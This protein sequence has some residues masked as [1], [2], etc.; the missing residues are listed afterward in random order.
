MADRVLLHIGAP[1]S[2]STFV[3]SLLWK[4]RSA[5]RG[6]GLLVPGRTPFDHNLA[7]MAV[8][9]A[10]AHSRMQHRAAATWQRLLGRI[11]QWPGSVVLS[12]EWFCWAA[13]DGVDR[14]LA[15]LAPTP[16]H[17]LFTA[18]AIAQQVPAAW[19]ETLKV[20][21]G[22]S[23]D[24]FVERLD[25]PGARWSW[26]T[27]DPAE[28]LVRWARSVPTERVHLA[29][30]PPRGSDPGLLW[31]RVCQVLGIDAAAYDADSPHA[32]ESLGVESAALL[33][34]AGPQLRDAILDEDADW[35]DPYR[36][37]RNYLGHQLLVPRRGS[38]IALPAPLVAGLAERAKRSVEVLAAQ[39]YD[40]VGSLE[41]LLLTD[42][43]A[44][45]RSPQEVS[46]AELL[47]VALPL[48]VELLGE[49]RRQ[50]LRAEAAHRRPQQLD[51]EQADPEQASLDAPPVPPRGEPS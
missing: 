5:L 6:D 51:P 13:A 44:G 35:A 17:L 9:T 21:S 43:P 10:T 37:L 14:A 7:S 27:I 15:E 47:D 24:R 12:N 48:V 36:W 34:R 49:V 29:T 2:G 22:E 20:G 38:A 39:G 33:Q 50:T 30:V 3:Q 18:R 41:D 28:S 4:H 45:G 1:K 16:V 26:S 25:E 23:I 42:Q 46:D 40:V 8:R 31:E 32:N 19:Q 11:R